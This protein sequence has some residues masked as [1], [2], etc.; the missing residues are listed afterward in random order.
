MSG[1]LTTGQLILTVPTTNTDAFDRMRISLPNTLFELNHGN[2]KLPFLIDEYISGAGATS[3]FHPNN[4]YIEM[5]LAP[6]ATGKVIRQSFEYVPYQ[7]GKSKFM[8]FSGVLEAIS[9]G[10]T[11][12]VSR[13]GCFDGGVEKV[14]PTTGTGN[15]LY[16]ELN[17]KVLSVCIRNNS[18]SA[19]NDNDNVTSV[20][21][22]SWNYDKFDG[23]GPSKIVMNDY[24]KAMIFGIDQEWLGSGRVRFGFF[25]NGTFYL[26]HTFNHSGLGLP[27]SAAITI[28]YTRTAKMPIRYEIQSSINPGITAEMRMV[29]STVLSEGGLDP[30]GITYSIGRVTPKTI[31]KSPSTFTPIISLKLKESEPYNRKTAVLQTISIF[32]NS[33]AGMQWD[34]YV[35]P[36]DSYLTGAVF[37]DVNSI[38]VTQYDVSATAVNLTNAV[39]VQSAF[40]DYYNNINFEGGSYLSQPLLNSSIKGKSRVFCLVGYVLDGINQNINS[41]GSF[42]WIE[43]TT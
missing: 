26:C 18:T 6:G 17:N 43:L 2:G 37:K 15:G 13:I 24:S 22:T 11:G 19:G 20:A 4:S 21:Q 39:A 10:V 8:L 12:V 3:I 31:P 38:S 27:V 36:D 42:K 33:N 14:A 35:L 16:F 9:G 5:S 30:N 32:N 7:T 1:T 34:L 25:I 29:C 41:Y 23:A 28:P 40:A